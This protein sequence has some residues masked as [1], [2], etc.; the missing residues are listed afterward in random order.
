MSQTSS[1]QPKRTLKAS[2]R[3]MRLAFLVMIGLTIPVLITAWHQMEQVRATTVQ[4]EELQAKLAGQNAQNEAMTLE[5]ERM[6]DPEYRQ[7]IIR[8]ELNYAK[9][10]ETVFEPSDAGR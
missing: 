2:V 9:P 1:R 5:L 8:S 10:G 6:N 7:E 3:R 4:L